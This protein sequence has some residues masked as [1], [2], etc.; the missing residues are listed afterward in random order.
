MPWCTLCEIANT[1][2]KDASTNSLKPLWCAQQPYQ[3][4][5][6]QH[7]T[8]FKRRPG[9]TTTTIQ[10]PPRPD[11]AIR[12]NLA[13]RV[14]CGKVTHA[15]SQEEVSW[16]HVSNKWYIWWSLKWACRNIDFVYVCTHLI[17][18][19]F[20]SQWYFSNLSSSLM[21]SCATFRGQYT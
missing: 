5:E 20:A 15:Q 19:P 6:Q 3:V 11:N 14:G 4:V 13:L 2:L 12:H 16:A 10:T 8:L 1:H 7:F 9:G 17:V 21:L 18:L